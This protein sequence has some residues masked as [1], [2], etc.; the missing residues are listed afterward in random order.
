[1]RME[2]VETAAA[3]APS[4]PRF[5]AHP[6][7]RPNSHLCYLLPGGGDALAGAQARGSGRVQLHGG[8]GVVARK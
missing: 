3:A 8:A 7:P 4:Q 1:M 6:P 2:Q 5:R